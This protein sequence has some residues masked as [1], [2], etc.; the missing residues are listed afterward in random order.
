MLL[1]SKKQCKYIISVVKWI[2][3]PPDQINLFGRT[4][5]C[6]LCLDGEHDTVCLILTGPILHAL[7]YIMELRIPGYVCVCAH[8]Y[9]CFMRACSVHAFAFLMSSCIITRS[10]TGAVPCS[11]LHGL[12]AREGSQPLAGPAQMH[13][14]KWRRAWILRDLR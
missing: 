1:Y 9:T 14:E 2:R 10:Y 3:T 12:A 13:I 5:D 7:L 8:T 4:E 11:F 6:I